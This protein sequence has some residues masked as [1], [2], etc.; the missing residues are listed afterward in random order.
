MENLSEEALQCL[1]KGHMIEKGKFRDE[2]YDTIP[3][4]ITHELTEYFKKNHKGL[5]LVFIFGNKIITREL[6][7]GLTEIEM[8]NLVYDLKTE[9]EVFIKTFLRWIADNVIELDNTG[10]NLKDG[11][12]FNVN[13]IFKIFKK[14]IDELSIETKKEI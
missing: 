14:E 7:N 3:L 9:D 4:D 11:L 8:E 1:E 2:Y 12:S 6:L 13:K 5:G 10:E